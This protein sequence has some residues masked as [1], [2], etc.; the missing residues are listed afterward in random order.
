MVS[1]IQN[2]TPGDI[3]RAALVAQLQRGEAPSY[4]AIMAMYVKG[5]K[6]AGTPSQGLSTYVKQEDGATVMEPVGGSSITGFI[7][8]VEID[9]SRMH[10]GKPVPKLNIVIN[11]AE[12]RFDGG[13]V[14]YG[15]Q[16]LVTCGAYSTMGGNILAS[17]AAVDDWTI[18]YRIVAR[19]PKEKPFLSYSQVYLN[20]PAN[21]NHDL[22]NREVRNEL[23]RIGVEEGD[24]KAKRALIDELAE[25]ICVITTGQP[26]PEAFTIEPAQTVVHEMPALTAAAN[27]D[28]DAWDGVPDRDAIDL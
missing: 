22:L 8:S 19:I 10:D 14:R 26:A 5:D 2:L 28:G 7:Q 11:P 23:F 16:I 20:N 3:Q 18:P 9:H 15:Y 17:L 13:W 25:S 4:A 21:R 1:S 27:A 24:I 12:P 6:S